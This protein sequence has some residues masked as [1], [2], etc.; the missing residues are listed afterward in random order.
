MRKNL[1]L[2]KLGGS[3]IT[4]KV[5]PFTPNMQHI[6]FLA[7][8]LRQARDEF[9]E[10]DFLVGNGAGS[11]GHFPA[12]QYGLKNGAR[13]PEQLYGMCVTHNYVRELNDLVATEL[14]SKKLPAFTISPSSIFMHHGG[15]IASANLDPVDE[16]LSRHCIPVVYGDTICDDI[17]GTSI[18]STEEVLHACM[19]PLRSGYAMVTVLY[20]LDSAGVLDD[21]GQVIP[22][23]GANDNVI[24]R[25]HLE[26]DVTGGIM[27]KIAS[28][29]K[30]A[31][32]ADVV[33]LADGR[34]PGIIRRAI[35]GEDVGTKI[36]V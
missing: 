16:L 32:M 8:E 20:L 36:I 24:E 28:A 30:A 23:L 13:T 21:N 18:M 6:K 12:H 7:E 27:A 15:Q 35:I 5:K 19:Q 10:V 25:L 31:K 4:D 26:H 1:V 9:T 2:I 17:L 22:R 34:E 11:Y 33:Y 29:R 3:L 14:I